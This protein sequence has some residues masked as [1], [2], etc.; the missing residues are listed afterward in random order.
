[1]SDLL[2]EDKTLIRTFMHMAEASFAARPHWLGLSAHGLSALDGHG[3]RGGIGNAGVPS[4]SASIPATPLEVLIAPTADSTSSHPL[5][6]HYESTP[7]PPLVHTTSPP[8]VH[9][10]V[11]RGMQWQ[12]CARR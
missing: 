4:E 6:V 1:M 9:Y 5:R 11:L 7:R 12:R 2:G 8:L 3:K 10:S